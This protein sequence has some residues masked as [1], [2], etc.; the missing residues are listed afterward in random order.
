M[1]SK[2]RIWLNAVLLL[3]A[4]SIGCLLPTWAFV[5]AYPGFQFLSTWPIVTCVGMLWMFPAMWGYFYDQT[6]KL[7]FR[8]NPFLKT[9]IL[10]GLKAPFYNP[11]SYV[12]IVFIDDLVTFVALLLCIFATTVI[13]SVTY[14][15]LIKLVNKADCWIRPV[16]SVENSG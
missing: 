12:I 11:L 15:L 2:G 16:E 3:L 13:C 4:T 6:Q 14:W 10:L 1:L 7:I 5:G 8:G 9:F